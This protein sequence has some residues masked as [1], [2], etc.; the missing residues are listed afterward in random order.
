MKGNN[1]T[2]SPCCH[3]FFGEW[4]AVRPACFKVLESWHP[5]LSEKEIVMLH[6]DEVTESGV[7]ESL[8]TRDLFSPRKAVIYQEPDFL[9]P[10][11][12]KKELAARLQKALDQGRR[13]RAARILGAIMKE[14]K[15][16]LADIESGKKAVFRKLALPEAMDLSSVCSIAREYSGK[17]EQI[18]HDQASSSGDRI[19]EWILQA[20]RGKKARDVF[21]AIHLE[22][23]DRRNRLLKRFMNTCQ[24]TDLGGSSERYGK[25]SAALQAHVRAW[26]SEQG[27][28]IEPRA[29]RFF[30]EKVG[31]GS[32]SA[33]KNEAEKLASLSGQ[34]KTI[35]LEDAR[36]L[37]VRHRE[38]EIFKVTDAFRSRNLKRA[39]ESSRMLI[40]QGIHPLAVLSAIRN[41]LVRIFAMKV[42]A[43]A[44]GLD[45]VLQNVSYQAFKNNYWDKLTAVFER[46][47]D[48]PLAGLHPYAAYLNVAALGRFSQGEILE[49]LEEMP[50]LDFSLKGGKA[51]PDTVLETF[52]LKNL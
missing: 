24:V 29:L 4:Q 52:F 45:G 46:F 13:D 17:I 25:K 6:G 33:L 50:E 11:G 23:P 12:R 42:A 35:T 38:E 48:N 28:D 34:R 10:G 51:P 31:E 43:A 26:L 49:M 47:D 8:K 21:L 18:L 15:I 9:Q 36:R 32:L 14:K 22:R 30:M 20:S 44:A 19:L 5:G 27:K 41:L 2:K 3:L 37:V 7:L 16:T 39:L 1:G 40:S